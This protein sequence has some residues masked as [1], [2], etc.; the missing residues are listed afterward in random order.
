MVALDHFEVTFWHMTVILVHLGVV[1]RSL[2]DGFGALWGDCGVT[3]KCVWCHVRGTL[4][5]WRCPWVA[6]ALSL[7]HI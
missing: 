6:L 4:G 3:L 5:I 7:I 1:W 2:W